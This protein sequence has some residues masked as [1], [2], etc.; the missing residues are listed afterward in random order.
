[1]AEPLIDEDI[2]GRITGATDVI[3]A[4]VVWVLATRVRT[5][6]VLAVWRTELVDRFTSNGQ[7][8]CDHD[9]LRS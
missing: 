7:K 6:R 4:D 1:V 8:I 5:E 3:A 2:A 9:L